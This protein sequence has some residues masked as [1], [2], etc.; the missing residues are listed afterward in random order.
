MIWKY[1]YLLPSSK[2]LS[3]ETNKIFKIICF[4][5]EFG[6]AFL[7]YHKQDIYA[8]S[9]TLFDPWGLQNVT[10]LTTQLNRYDTGHSSIR[11][12]INKWDRWVRGTIDNIKCSYEMSLL[13]RQILKWLGNHSKN[14]LYE[15]SKCACVYIIFAMDPYN[16]SQSAGAIFLDY[17]QTCWVLC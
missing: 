10:K 4:N 1:K 15:P 6:P 7:S 5:S 3:Q 17:S 8:E 13:H 9:C 12:M 11:S 14:T 16:G 2:K